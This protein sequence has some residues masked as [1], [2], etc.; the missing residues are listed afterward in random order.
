MALDEKLREEIA[1]TIWDDRDWMKDTFRDVTGKKKSDQAIMKQVIEQLKN[2]DGSQNI[3]LDF[4]SKF[5][6][7]Q[8][9]QPFRAR[10]NSRVVIFEPYRTKQ[11]REVEGA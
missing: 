3:L 5:S 11:Q 7:L 4:I 1:A 10:D 6:N 2:Y 8:K 9:P